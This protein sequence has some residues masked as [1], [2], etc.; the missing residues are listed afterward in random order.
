MGTILEI[1]AKEAR[2]L[3]E[4]SNFILNVFYKNIKNIAEKG[5]SCFRYGYGGEED[6]QILE[7]ALKQ[8]ESLGF[9]IIRQLEADEQ[10][11]DIYG[12]IIVKW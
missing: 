11:N 4:Q 9:T 10:T 3:T 5:G 6:M 1:S 2:K 12:E 8:L 7:N